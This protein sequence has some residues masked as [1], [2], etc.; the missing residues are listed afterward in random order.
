MMQKS[1]VNSFPVSLV[2]IQVSHLASVTYRRGEQEGSAGAI[3]P[4]F[5]AM[6]IFAQMCCP[7]STGH[8]VG[9]YT[10]QEPQ[11]LVVPN[12]HNLL[13]VIRT[14]GCA[15]TVVVPTSLEGV[16]PISGSD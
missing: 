7:L 14:T 13:E 2:V 4:T 12:A 15:I 1:Y 11:S 10:P 5:H 9:L 8:F 6:G 16:S 3:L